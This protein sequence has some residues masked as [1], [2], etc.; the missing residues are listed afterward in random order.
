MRAVTA[1]LSCGL[2]LPITLS[3]SNAHGLGF[4]MSLGYLSMDY[5]NIVRAMTDARAVDEAIKGLK[6]SA[7]R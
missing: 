2:W 4:I 7:G 6:E 5:F 3:L 1:F